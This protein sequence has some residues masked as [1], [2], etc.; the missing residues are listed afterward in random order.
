MGNELGHRRRREGALERTGEA[1]MCILNFF[2]GSSIVV[3][4]TT[5]EVVI[6]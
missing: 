3:L 5:D 6:K 4:F 2:F 1:F